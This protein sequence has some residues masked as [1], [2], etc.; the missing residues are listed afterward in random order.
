MQAPPHAL[1]KRLDA[2]GLVADQQRR[3]MPHALRDRHLSPGDS[4]FA[5]A[6][7]PVI[8]L[9]LDKEVVPGP[10][11][12]RERLNIRDL[13]FLTFAPF[14]LLRTAPLLPESKAVK[15]R[16]SGA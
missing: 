3:Q 5:H 13:H 4:G 14:P 9:H 2:V 12:D 1:P 10:P 11:S 7:D 15:C 8:C 16:R 6:P